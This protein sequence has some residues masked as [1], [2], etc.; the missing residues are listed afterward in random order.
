MK[1][2]GKIAVVT[3][4]GQGLGRRIALALA[5]EG[6]NLVLCSR[7]EAELSQVAEDIRHSDHSSLPVRADIG[8]PQDVDALIQAALDAYGRI[9]ILV[10]NAAV[11]GPIGPLAEVVE[12]EWI[13]TI[14]TNLFGTFHCIRRALPHMVAARKGKIIN[15]SGGGATTARPNFSAYAASKAAIVRLTETLAVEVAA[16][17]VQVNA[18]APGA[19]P[20]RMQQEILAAR[21]RAG[22]AEIQVAQSTEKNDAASFATATA[23]A[24]YLASDAS[25]SLTGKLIS[26]QYDGWETWDR[27]QIDRLMSSPWLTLRRLDEFTLSRLTDHDKP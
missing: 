9:D 13:Q 19:L 16:S 6:A 25:G 10:N 2:D 3:G 8:K 18:I 22:E 1:L 4:A 24:V 14:Q 15:L 20:T 12:L 11:Q 23:L 26:A 17:N 21:E 5:C 27:G 7:N